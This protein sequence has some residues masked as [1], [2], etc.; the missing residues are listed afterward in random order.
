MLVGNFQSAR[1]NNIKVESWMNIYILIDF[2][3]LEQKKKK[4]KRKKKKRKK[5]KKKQKDMLHLQWKER[6]DIDTTK[7]S[8]VENAVD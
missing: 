4:K 1:L 8:Q 3:S 5:K 6:M 7:L 2:V